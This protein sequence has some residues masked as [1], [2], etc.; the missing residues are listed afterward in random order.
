[1]DIDF[2]INSSNDNNGNLNL[3][4][5]DINNDESRMM[6][7]NGNR[8]YS[9]NI[10]IEPNHEFEIQEIKYDGEEIYKEYLSHLFVRVSLL[11]F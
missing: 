5:R 6:L 7:Q 10:S 3:Q 2:T 4:E 11:F 9:V 1:M 8:H